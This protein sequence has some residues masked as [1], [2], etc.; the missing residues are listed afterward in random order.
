MYCR[1]S[2]V[3]RFKARYSF[4]SPNPANIMDLLDCVRISELLVV[5][6]PA[7]EPITEDQ[8]QLFSILLAQGQPVMLHL[9]VGLPQ[10]GKHRDKM[11][12]TL[13]RSMANWPSLAD[14]K[15]HNFDSDSE[16][17]KILRAISSMQKKPIILQQRHPHLLAEQ[18]CVEETAENADEVG[19]A[20]EVFF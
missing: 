18:L 17:L 13:E 6:W 19:D 4:L 2:S 5:V 11:R 3:P 15:V 8:R 7:E 1:H 14:E 10:N 9:T 16:A 12:K 20:A